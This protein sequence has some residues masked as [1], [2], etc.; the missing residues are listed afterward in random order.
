MRSSC[1]NRCAALV[2]AVALATSTASARAPVQDTERTVLLWPLVID[3]AIEPAARAELDA[4]ARVGLER[5]SMTSAALDSSQ[6]AAAAACA[7]AGCAAALALDVGVRWVVRPVL[8]VDDRNWQ[9]TATLISAGDGSTL[10]TVDAT[11]ELCGNAE[12]AE[13]LA[14]QIATLAEKIERLDP[15]PAQLVLRTDPDGAEIEVDDRALGRSPRSLRLSAG[16]HRVVVRKPGFTTIARSV[17]LVAGVD[18]SL[19]LELSRSPRP[20]FGAG[21]GMLIGGVALVGAGAPLWA[22]DGRPYEKR[23]SGDD[24]D[25]AGTCRY[26]YD[27]STAG[28]VLTSIGVAAAITGIALLAHSRRVARRR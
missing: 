14:H 2:V 12:V 16:R 24:V 10:A 20:L 11:C 27:T 6:S 4:A 28:I 9:I 1:R 15:E 19:T 21:L 7:D 18:E 8:R 25:F 5:A 26:V 22:I 17:D 23:C 13:E 3:A